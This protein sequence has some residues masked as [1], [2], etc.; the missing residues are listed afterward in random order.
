[1][2]SG[3]LCL[4]QGQ[5]V[6]YRG[7]VDEERETLFELLLNKNGDNRALVDDRVA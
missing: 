3:C 4:K 2:E 5:S 1:M 7:D 6:V